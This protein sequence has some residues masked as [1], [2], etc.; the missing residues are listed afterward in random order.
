MRALYRPL[1]A[2]LAFTGVVQ[3]DP[4]MSSLKAAFQQSRAERN[5]DL[6]LPVFMRSK[7]YIVTGGK[8]ESKDY[9]LAPSPDKDRFCITVSEEIENL[10]N[11]S[12]PKTEVSGEKLIKEL[13]PNIEIV[14]FYKDGG[15][16]ITREHLQWYRGLINK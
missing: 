4:N 3:A 15:D 12:W 5:I 1:L 6:V 11:I 13:P 14:I 16:Y 8:S 7:L 9:F 2:L 10:K